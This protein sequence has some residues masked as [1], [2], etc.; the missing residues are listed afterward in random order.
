MI[1]TKEMLTENSRTSNDLCFIYMLDFI[2]KSEGKLEYHDNASLLKSEGNPST[3][4]REGNSCVSK[5]FD[6]PRSKELLP[7]TRTSNFAHVSENYVD[8]SKQIS[9][10]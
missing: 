6:Q 2:L 5:G 10:L 1:K 3:E 9:S 8:V 7:T 4:N